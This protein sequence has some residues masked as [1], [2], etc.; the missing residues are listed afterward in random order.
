MHRNVDKYPE[1]EKTPGIVVV[2]LDAPLFFANTAHFENSIERHVKEGQREAHE[3][4]RES[5]PRLCKAAAAFRSAGL[6]LHACVAASRAVLL[7]G[8]PR[9][10]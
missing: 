8:S 10:V 6:A 1:A 5:H 3:A 7:M 9:P 2:R 4:G